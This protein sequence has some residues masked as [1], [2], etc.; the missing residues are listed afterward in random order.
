MHPIPTDS[1]LSSKRA[2]AATDQVGS[3]RRVQDQAGRAV[4]SLVFV[5]HCLVYT[6]G[7]TKSDALASVFFRGRVML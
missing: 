1:C 6:E 5:L 2:E 7:H 4:F 3:K